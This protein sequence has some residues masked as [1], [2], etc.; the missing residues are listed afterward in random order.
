MQNINAQQGDIKSRYVRFHL[1]SSS[2]P[3]DLTNNTVKVFAI[4]PDNTLI[5]NNVTIEDAA[6]GQILVELTS[7]T[8]AIRGYLNCQLKIYGSD[9]SILSSSKF[10]INVLESLDDTGAI[11]SQNEFTALTVALADLAEYEQYKTDVDILKT[12]M[13]TDPLTT[14]AQN[15]KGAINEVNSDLAGNANQLLNKSIDALYPPI[16]AIPCILDNVADD[17]TAL[18]NLI[19]FAQL[20]NIKTVFIPYTTTGVK[21]SGTITIDPTKILLLGNHTKFNFSNDGIAVKFATSSVMGMYD[22][23]MGI[24]GI[25]LTGANTDGLHTNTVGVQFSD[26]TGNYAPGVGIRKCKIHEFNKGMTWSNNTW[27]TRVIESE[28][29]HCTTAIYFP[30]GTTNSGEQIIFDKSDIFNCDNGVYN[31]GCQMRFNQCSFDYINY[32]YVN[33]G[34]GGYTTLNDCH[35]EGDKDFDYWLYT[36][37]S[38]SMILMKGGSIGVKGTKSAYPVGNGLTSDGGIHLENVL[39]LKIGTGSYNF[40]G[41][42]TGWS[43]SRNLLPYVAGTAISSVMGTDY[44]NY[45]TNGSFENTGIN[46]WTSVGTGVGGYDSTIKHSGSNSFKMASQSAKYVQYQIDIPCTPMQKPKMVIWANINFGTSNDTV[47]I[48]SQY[49]DS[50]GR[51]LGSAY[52]LTLTKNS[53]NVNTWKMYRTNP[54]T[55]AVFGTVKC[56]FILQQA[57]STTLSD[58][59]LVSA[60]FDDAIIV[61]E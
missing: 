47:T 16:P 59:L 44:A 46:E 27:L 2:L 56:R 11:E 58:G 31:S 29:W 33:S 36:S 42:I 40:P 5:F 20:N 38:N 4:K 34:G 15:V 55:P 60:N 48:T 22:H 18:Q 41:L 14:T 53:S 24:E 32:K 50:L 37:G 39:Y 30:S 25:E 13:G 26:N 49:I 52:A 3:V 43:T 45:L 54:T 51:V 35:V 23:I 8:L 10:Q 9:E 1:I 12:N 57:S 21:L 28:I 6:N 61:V 19:N 7:Q 17:T